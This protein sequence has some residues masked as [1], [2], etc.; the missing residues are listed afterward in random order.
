MFA[1]LKVFQTAMAMANHASLRQRLTAQ[2]LAHADTP[3]FRAK[4]LASFKDNYAKSARSGM[5]ATRPAHFGRPLPG[6]RWSIEE[7][8]AP[9]DPNG[10]T[11]SVELEMVNAANIRSQHNRALAVYRSSMT[12][13]RASLGRF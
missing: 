2:N 10:N 7:T 12:I 13:L 6:N 1:D 8:A 9:S 11:V 4:S 3:G 5:I